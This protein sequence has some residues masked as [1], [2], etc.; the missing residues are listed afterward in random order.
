M[1]AEMTVLNVDDYEAARYAK[2]RLLRNA[3][4]RVIEASSGIEALDMCSRLCPQLVLLDVKLPDIDGR[5]VCRRMKRDPATRDVRVVQ[6][7]AAYI[8]RADVASGLAS[9]ADDYVTAPFEPRQLI[10]A[11]RGPV[12]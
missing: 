3:G 7:S 11:L 2:T 4:F 5:E 1:A 9:G 10:V 12:Q 8:S 6:T